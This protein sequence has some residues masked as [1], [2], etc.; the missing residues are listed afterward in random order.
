M[1]TVMQLK[2]LYFTNMPLCYSCL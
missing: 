1:H 2:S